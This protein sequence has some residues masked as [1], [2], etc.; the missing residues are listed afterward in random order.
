MNQDLGYTLNVVLLYNVVHAIKVKKK[1][2]EEDGIKVLLAEPERP[3]W[4]EI[5][6][7]RWETR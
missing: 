7:G 3:N 2:K 5:E 1:K 6:G 4:D